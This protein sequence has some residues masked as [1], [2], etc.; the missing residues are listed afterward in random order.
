MDPGKVRDVV[1]WQEQGY[2]RQAD[3][4]RQPVTL[5]VGDW[6]YLS[7]KNLRGLQGSRKLGGNLFKKAPPPDDWHPRPA[8]PALVTVRGEPHHE[9][10]EV[11]GSQVHRGRL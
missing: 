8:T 5:T 11:L 2:K 1:Q 7:T 10:E 3:K 6:M 9:V 4:K